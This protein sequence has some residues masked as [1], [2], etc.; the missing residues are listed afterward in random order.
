M[1]PASRTLEGLYVDDHLFF[2]VVDKKQYR[3]RVENEDVKLLDASR[4]RYAELGLP[5]SSKKGFEKEYTFKAWGT[6]VDSA[7]GR[8]GAPVEKLRQIEESI[9]KINW[10][11]RSPIY[12]SS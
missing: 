7:S 10:S 2:Q 6:C 5:R 9:A 8:V 3:S 11:L 1:F 4:Q 12:A